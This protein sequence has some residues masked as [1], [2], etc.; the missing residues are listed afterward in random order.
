MSLSIT[1]SFRAITA[2]RREGLSGAESQAAQ[3]QERP[4]CSIRNL[5]QDATV[6][7]MILMAN[8]FEN[9]RQVVVWPFIVPWLYARTRT[10]CLA[11]RDTTAPV[12]PVAHRSKEAVLVTKPS[13][14]LIPERALQFA[15]PSPRIPPTWVHGNLAGQLCRL[16]VAGRFVRSG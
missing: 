9:K 15:K 4:L 6:P 11:S 10:V 8:N 1:S 13:S 12:S 2:H 5:K 16:S 7:D 3:N 14:V